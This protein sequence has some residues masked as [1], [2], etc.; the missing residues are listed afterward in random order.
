M[1]QAKPTS[2]PEKIVGSTGGEDC[3]DGWRGSRVGPHMPHMLAHA[4]HAHTSAQAR[5]YTPAH[6]AHTRTCHTHL[7]QHHVWCAKQSCTFRTC[8]LACLVQICFSSPCQ[9][10]GPTLLSPS[11]PRLRPPLP[12]RSQASPSCHP[13]TP[14]LSFLSPSDSR[15]LPPLTIRP[16]ALPQQ[17]NVRRVLIVLDTRQDFRN[18]K[19]G[20]SECSVAVEGVSQEAADQR[21][22]EGEK[23]SAWMWCTCT[24]V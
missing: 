5:P 17:Q 21:M 16:Q 7:R 19:S 11:D 4:T 13:Q 12:L 9:T 22:S 20:Q 10:L 8:H 15:P 2:A 18:Q 14:G 24:H 23:G 3:K 1:G 6:T